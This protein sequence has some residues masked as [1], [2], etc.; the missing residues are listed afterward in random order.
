MNVFLFAST[1][2]LLFPLP[3]PTPVPCPTLKLHLPAQMQA[4]GLSDDLLGKMHGNRAEAFLQLKEFDK[5]IEDAQA[6]LE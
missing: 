3:P 6:S 4:A 1:L 2:P 5:C